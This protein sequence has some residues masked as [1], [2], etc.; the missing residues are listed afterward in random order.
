[1]PL[2]LA[3]EH[4]ARR[5]EFQGFVDEH[6]A[7]FADAFHRAQR[8][9]PELI[10]LLAERGYLGIS[11]PK[12]F[13]GAGED[14]VTL[15]LL[16]AELARGCSSV[17]S[18]L[19]V[20]TM[21]A[22]AILRW[23]TRA[24][25]ERW[26]PELASG[27]RIGALALSEPGV[28]SDA[29][30]VTTRIAA[31]GTDLVIDGEKRWI[32]Y[33]EIADL[34]LVFGRTEEGP[35]A[36]LVERGRPGLRTEPIRDLLGIRASMTA[37]VHLDGC[38]VEADHV[39]GRRGL[40]ITQVASVA[41][42]LGRYTVAWGCVGILRACVEACVAYTSRREQFGAPLKEHQLVRRMISDMFTDLHASEMLCMEAGRLRDRRDPGA[43]SATAMAKYFASTAA[44]RAAGDAV[45]LHGANGCSADYPLQR[46]LGDARIMEIIEGSS[47][48]QQITIAEYAY[49][50]HGGA[51]RRG[52]AAPSKEP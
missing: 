25:R 17:R 46:L 33:G 27:R 19:T 15:G 42:D 37:S 31:Q 52:P 39:V 12:E 3:P 24:Q 7:P 32:T 29:K 6:V 14:A 48:I 49:L 47:Q 28:G 30:S 41:L 23:G 16:A 11:I 10:A 9:P 35:T 45:Q 18:L 43:L 34:F 5:V 38:R 4:E 2:S 22:L 36:V 51:G 1:M 8:T 20:H 13:G 26:L 21:V 40:G 50:E 44:V